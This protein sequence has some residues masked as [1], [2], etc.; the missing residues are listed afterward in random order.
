V[1]EG[2]CNAEATSGNT[3]E[4]VRGVQTTERQVADLED[5]CRE[6]ERFVELI[7]EISGQ[8]RMLAL[9]ATIEATRAGE[10]G[11]GFVVVANE[12]KGLAKQ[13]SEMAEMIGVQAHEITEST[14]TLSSSMAQ[15][16]KLVGEIDQSAASIVDQVE[17]QYGAIG[18]IQ[19]SAHDA[20]HSSVNAH[21]ATASA[22][23]EA[24]LTGETADHFNREAER[25]AREASDTRTAVTEFLM[26]L[27]ADQT[28]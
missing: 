18:D 28:S 4:A 16:T 5:R 6:I 8:T 1:A 24:V 13:T 21:K 14:T 17:R 27:R 11:K 2:R 22:S 7:N 15:V 20:Q 19:T 12:V 25:L 23:Q 9:N 26:Q 10:A 3:S